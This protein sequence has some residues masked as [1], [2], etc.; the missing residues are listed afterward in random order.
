MREIKTI[1]HQFDR[2]QHHHQLLLN[3]LAIKERS[4]KRMTIE[5]DISNL[6]AEEDINYLSN[7][8]RGDKGH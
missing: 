1:V 5:L 6:L 8:L 2:N 4:I 7:H 3:R